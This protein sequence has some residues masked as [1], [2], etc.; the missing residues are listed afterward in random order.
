[1]ALAGDMG[2]LFFYPVQIQGPYIWFCLFLLS[3]SR[4]ERSFKLILGGKN[5]LKRYMLY[6]DAKQI[7]SGGG[8]SRRTKGWIGMRSK[9]ALGQKKDSR[10]SSRPGRGPLVPLPFLCG[11]L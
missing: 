4:V 5:G 3:P 8:P 9:E 10:G 6:T 7:P 1:M 11:Q 2:K